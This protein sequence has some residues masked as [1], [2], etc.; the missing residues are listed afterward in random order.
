[1]NDADFHQ[2]NVATAIFF[3]LN[4][5]AFNFGA[6]TPDNQQ[7]YIKKCVEEIKKRTNMTEG[8]DQSLIDKLTF[9]KIKKYINR[10]YKVKPNGF[11]NDFLCLFAAW[12]YAF[13]QNATLNDFFAKLFFAD[14]E[15]S[16]SRIFNLMQQ[17]EKPAD[18]MK[19]VTFYDGLESFMCHATDLGIEI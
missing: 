12:I 13:N 10:F 2:F 6:E 5:D 19:Y 15:K 8:F 7:D 14:L 18:G 9:H 11:Y 1:M 16:I 17:T 3:G 4:L